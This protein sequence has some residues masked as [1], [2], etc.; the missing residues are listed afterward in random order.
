MADFLGY[1]SLAAPILANKTSLLV[2]NRRYIADMQRVRTHSPV[3]Q[4]AALLLGNRVRLARRQ[5]RWTVE[6]LA[7]RVGVGVAT[8]RKVERGDLT[9]AIGTAFEAAA[10]AGVVL[11]AEDAPRRRL[12]VGRVAD[13]LAVLPK[14]VRVPNTIDDN[15]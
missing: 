10:I 1:Q 11:F 3:T 7:T 5:R 14:L 6:E 8:M 4:E 9:V 13:Q 2:A 12:E 15:F